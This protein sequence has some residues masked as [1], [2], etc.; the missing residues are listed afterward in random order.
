M[1][2]MRLRP[3]AWSLIAMLI[4]AF[5]LLVTGCPFSEPA[6]PLAVENSEEQ[7]IADHTVVDKYGT[8]PQYW[9]DQVKKM[10]LDATGESHSQAYRVGLSLLA[11]IDARFSVSVVE[12]GTPEPYTDQNLRASRATWGEG[13]ES[14]SGWNYWGYG[15]EDWYTSDLAIS[16]TKA[17]IA[18]C[19]SNGL[20][21]AAFGFAWCWD[22]CWHNDPGGDEDPIYKVHWAGSSVG[23][24]QGDTRWGLDLADQGITGNSICM[25]TYLDATQQYVDFCRVNRYTTRVFFTTGPVDN[26]SGESAYQMQLKQDFIRDYVR[27]DC[28]R[29]LFDYADILV[30]SDAGTLSTGRLD[31]WL[32]DGPF[33]SVCRTGQPTYPFGRYRN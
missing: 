23:G 13:I 2:K 33:L 3:K 24:P 7:I 20:T 12:S 9:I 17:H 1:S 8:I 11:S 15:E 10:W 21:I 30:W 28:T 19:N 26:V 25:Q 16:R 29:I 27:A 22:M 32:W 5:L 31:G 6:N 4:E 14:D 18:Y